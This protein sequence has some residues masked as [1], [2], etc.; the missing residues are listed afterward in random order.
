MASGTG[1]TLDELTAPMPVDDASVVMRPLVA[2]QRLGLMSDETIDMPMSAAQMAI[3]S[4]VPDIHLPS[5]GTAGDYSMPMM[6]L[7]NSMNMAAPAPGPITFLSFIIH[8]PRTSWTYH[9]NPALQ[10]FQCH[11]AQLI[12]GIPR[13]LLSSFQRAAVLGSLSVASTSV[14]GR[15]S[16]FL[17]PWVRNHF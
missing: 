3:D 11:L 9:L 8:L 7:S 6:G 10:L 4:I 13:L 16:S 1:P 5:I 14:V 17:R 2:S 15:R 12:T